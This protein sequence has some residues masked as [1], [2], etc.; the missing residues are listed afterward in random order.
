MSQPLVDAIGNPRVS[1][2]FTIDFKRISY[3]ALRYWY[4]IVLFLML[5][6]GISFLKN[7]Y[8]VRIYPVTASVIIREKE[9]ASGGDLLYKN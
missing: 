5:C 4:V 8:A 9:E 7:R 1:E 6:L 3:R 2:S